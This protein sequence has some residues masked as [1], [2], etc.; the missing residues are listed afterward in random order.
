M[1]IVLDLSSSPALVGVLFLL[2]GCGAVFG[3]H[4]LAQ[5]PSQLDEMAEPVRRRQLV[6]A[7]V[8]PKR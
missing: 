7:P 4:V 3:A 5:H 2:T 6:A 8:G 1:P